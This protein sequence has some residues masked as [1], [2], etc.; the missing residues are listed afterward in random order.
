VFVRLPKSLFASQ[1]ACV[2]ACICVR[3]WFFASPW[4]FIDFSVQNQKEVLMSAPVLRDR[5]SFRYVGAATSYFLSSPGPSFWRCLGVL[6]APFGPAR[7]YRLAFSYRS[8]SPQRPGRCPLAPLVPKCNVNLPRP[9]LVNAGFLS[10]PL[11]SGITSNQHPG[12]TTSLHLLFPC[13]QSLI[14]PSRL[15]LLSLVK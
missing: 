15:S 9:E 7:H 11:S 8:A 13:S 2:R 12:S 3:R 6:V 14:S 5:P 1:G 10:F 4:T